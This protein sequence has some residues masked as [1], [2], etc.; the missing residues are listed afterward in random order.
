MAISDENRN[1]WQKVAVALQYDP[2]TM[3]APMVGVS[4]CEELAREIS[5]LARRHG[6]PMVEDSAVAEELSHLNDRSTI[7]SALYGSVAKH[8]SQVSRRRSR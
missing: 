3:D 1:R 5:R 4:G 2:A 8:L 6:V 7:P